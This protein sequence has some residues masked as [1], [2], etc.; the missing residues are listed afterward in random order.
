M[1]RLLIFCSASAGI[2][3]SYN[4]AARKIVRAACAYGHSIVTGGTIKGTMGVI[5]DEVV[6]VGGQHV[7]VV[8]RFMKAIAYPRLTRTVWADTMSDR[9]A[10][11]REESDLALALPGGI[12]TLYELI[13]TQVLSKLGK[14]QGKIYAL[15]IGGFY[16]P[17]KSLLAHY[18]ATGMLEASDSARINIVDSVEEMVEILSQ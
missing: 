8:P 4:D 11:M 1:A 2:D 16:E 15:N 5:G 3:P 10:K 6:A 7:G 12:G 18:V 17:L 9:Q 14:Y 13:E